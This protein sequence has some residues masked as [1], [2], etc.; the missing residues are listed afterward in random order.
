[1]SSNTVKLSDS[2]YYPAFSTKKSNSSTNGVGGFKAPDPYLLQ[3][4]Y[5]PQESQQV[6]GEGFGVAGTFSSYTPERQNVLTPGEGDLTAGNRMPT[7]KPS[8]VKSEEPERHATGIENEIGQEVASGVG[9][10][11]S[12][13]SQTNKNLAVDDY[14]NNMADWQAQGKYWFHPDA[15][16][17][18]D[19]DAY[20]AALPSS[21][22]ALME[23]TLLGGSTDS[24][25]AA[26][27]LLNPAAFEGERGTYIGENAIDRA[28][29]GFSAGGWIGAIVGAAVG[30]VEGFFNWNSAE[31]TDAENKKKAQIEAEK[32]LKVWEQRRMARIKT[33]N[34]QVLEAKRQTRI[35]QRGAEEAKKE[36]KKVKSANSAVANRQ[37]MVNA[38]MG[39]GSISKANRDARLQRWS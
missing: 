39:A 11:L 30:V 19:V 33:Y 38:I 7:Q 35:A 29:T 25:A 5:N 20:V 17:R 27:I 12:E 3:S 28:S 18:P 6:R 2:N 26:S 34:D 4:G 13:M 10:F 24:N 37:A 36:N 15:D 9:S 23:S 22:D 32:N 16:L 31:E 8:D 1:M 21:K 14:K